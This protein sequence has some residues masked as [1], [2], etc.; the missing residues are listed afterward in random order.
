MRSQSEIYE[1]QV[2]EKFNKL[3]MKLSY[4]TYKNYNG[5]YSLEDIVQE[6]KI[7]AIRAL[8][9]FDSTKNV[10]LITHLHNYINFY[11]SHFTRDDTGLIKIPK[12]TKVEKENLPEIIDTEVFQS[13]YV[14]ERCPVFFEIE[15]DI[16]NKL[17]IENCLNS[18]SEKER[19]IIKLVFIEGY[20][21]NQVAELHNVS[22]QY[23]NA[24]AAKALNKLRNKFNEYANVQ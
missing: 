4:K 23:A 5:K 12:T 8:R 9:N 20:T 24:V 15:T 7:G 18:L 6:A 16:E 19:M 11:L 14:N 2:L 1:E 3:I 22:R 17:F 21:Y 13:N 10:K